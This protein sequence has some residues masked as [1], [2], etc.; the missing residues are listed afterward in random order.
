MKFWSVALLSLFVL[1]ACGQVEK[2]PNAVSPFN[3]KGGDDYNTKTE[4]C[5]TGEPAGSSIYQSSWSIFKLTS[6]NVQIQKT[7]AFQPNSITQTI[8]C[9]YNGK[10]VT[11]TA[12]ANASIDDKDHSFLVT[13]AASNVAILN[14]ASKDYE[15][16][17]EITARPTEPVKF[18]FLGECL[19]LIE[20]IGNEVTYIP[21][22]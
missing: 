12:T 18:K 11:A 22:K 9:T 21:T 14:V 20:A 3:N 17:S 8:N 13:T 6:N 16:K 2:D 15:C 1:V 19:R 10:M 5:G 7:L 4:G